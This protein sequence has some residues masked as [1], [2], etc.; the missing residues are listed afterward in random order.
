MARFNGGFVPMAKRVGIPDFRRDDMILASKF[1]VSDTDKS[2][3]FKIPTSEI[4][5]ALGISRPRAER[6]QSWDRFMMVTNLW[7]SMADHQVPKPFDYRPRAPN[8]EVTLQ[9]RH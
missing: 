2:G 8:I 1:R 9:S 7:S 3:F 5:G 6:T 4:P